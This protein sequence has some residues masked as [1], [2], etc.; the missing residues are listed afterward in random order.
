MNRFIT[1]HYST[2]ITSKEKY[3][4]AY[5]VYQMGCDE[6]G[7]ELQKYGCNVHLSLTI[8]FILNLKFSRS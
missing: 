1:L 6:Y 2:D 3:I 4:H 7:S 8:K 5:E